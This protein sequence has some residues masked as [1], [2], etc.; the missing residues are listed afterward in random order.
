MTRG[1]KLQFFFHPFTP[2]HSSGGHIP[3]LALWLILNNASTLSCA[4]SS[5]WMMSSGCLELVRELCGRDRWCQRANF[6]RLHVPF[7]QREFCG[8]S[9]SSVDGAEAVDIFLKK[10]SHSFLWNEFAHKNS[11]LTCWI[12]CGS[13]EANFTKQRWSLWDPGTKLIRKGSKFAW[14]HHCRIFLRL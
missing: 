9:L 13:V 1:R 3:Y 8:Y 7:A 4:G 6:F 2:W 12:K 11:G 10:W 5:N 14:W